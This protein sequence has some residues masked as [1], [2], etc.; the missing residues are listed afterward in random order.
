M[1]DAF[2]LSI[3]GPDTTEIAG[4]ARRKRLRQIV[5]H[6]HVRGGSFAGVPHHDGVADVEDRLVAELRHPRQHLGDVDARKP[7]PHAGGGLTARDGQAAGVWTMCAPSRGW[8]ARAAGI[9][10]ALAV[11]ETNPELETAALPDAHR[12]GSAEQL[13]RRVRLRPDAGEAAVGHARAGRG[14]GSGA[15]VSVGAP[16]ANADVSESDDLQVRQRIRAGVPDVNRIRHFERGRTD[17][18]R[19]AGPDFD[20]QALRRHRLVHVGGACCSPAP[21]RSLRSGRWRLPYSRPTPAHRLPGSPARRT[22]PCR[23]P[24]G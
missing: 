22:S 3:D 21:D 8:F 19:L 23:Q 5:G 16:W 18:R 11:G 14:H 2:P 7:Q 6:L 4:A 17:D 9:A 13:R 15:Y 20:G 24:A 1:S 12:S 10:A